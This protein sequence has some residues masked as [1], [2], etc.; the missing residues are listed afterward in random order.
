[1]PPRIL[2]ADDSMMVRRQVT[3]ALVDA[4]Y[5]VIETADGADAHRKLTPDLALVICDLNMPKMNGMELLERIHADPTLAVVP[6]VMLTTEARPKIV[7]RARALGA[8]AWLIKPFKA[9]VF[10]TVVDKL[11]R[12]LS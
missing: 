10:L 2:V 7:D 4:G 6:F 3:S 9:D 8:K 11:A 5:A 12:R 1:M